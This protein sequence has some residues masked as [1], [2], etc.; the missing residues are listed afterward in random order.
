[1]QEKENKHTIK[2][3]FKEFS[4]YLVDFFM[5]VLIGLGISILLNV[6]MKFI[7]VIDI[8]LGSFVVHFLSMCIVLYVRSYRRSYSANTHTY[9]FQIKKALLYIGITFAVQMLLTIIIG[10]HAVYISGPTFWLMSFVFPDLDRTMAEG[11]AMLAGY[12]WLFMILADI[13]IYAPIMILGEYLGDKQNKKQL[14]EA[15]DS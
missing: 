12:D 5:S 10:G 1:M 3:N 4:Y 2:E 11:R 15:K 6:P 7:R 14:A 13:L 8:D 9:C